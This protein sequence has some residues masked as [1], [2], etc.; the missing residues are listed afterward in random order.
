MRGILIDH[1]P[2]ETRAA[3]VED[4][5][6]V[7]LRVDGVAAAARIGGIYHGRVTAKAPQ[8]RGAFVD[9]G[10]AEPPAFLPLARGE[11]VTVGK[12]VM[13]Q[14]RRD[15]AGGKG[16][17]VSREIVLAGRHLFLAPAGGVVKLSR[18]IGG[19]QRRRDLAAWA[20]AAIGGRGLVVRPAA[21]TA[22]IADLDRELAALGALWDDVVTAATTTP[23]TGV[24]MPP[25]GAALSLLLD[26]ARPDEI[27]VDDP[28]ILNTL[29][30]ACERLA[31]D[32]TDRLRMH[33]GAR[34]LFDAEGL[35]GQIA[36]LDEAVVPLPSGGRLIIQETAAL[37]VIDVDGG[38]TPNG[39]AGGAVARA[40]REAVAEVA[41][42]IRLR[43]LGGAVAVD[44]IGGAKAPQAART[45]EDLR[46]RTAGDPVGVHV[47]GRGPLG[48]VE[49]IRERR[50]APLSEW[51][52]RGM[53]FEAVR[54]VLR[55]AATPGAHPLRLRVA[56]EV[57]H[58][59]SGPAAAALDLAKRRLGRP[60]DV[61]ADRSLPPGDHDLGPAPDGD[62]A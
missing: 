29:R 27:M 39:G 23:P 30:G 56:P 62:A 9:L 4:G 53:A 33:R 36:A 6:L 24:L 20:E 37:A 13:V 58:D 32:L 10:G 52:R 44:F 2:G 61:V 12:A 47:L 17:R 50:Q 19:E 25:P 60:L 40:N 1:L 54:A 57:F 49:M 42:Q 28:G 3:L 8:L 59:L 55:E 35:S 46:Q 5:D 21:A 34:P 43:N 45:V 22:D 48:M 7:D 18:R 14:V 38:T 11:S 31:P 51:R 26:A 15:A 16:P 41:R